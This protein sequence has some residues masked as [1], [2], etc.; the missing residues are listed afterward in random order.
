VKDVLAQ[1]ERLASLI[2][3]SIEPKILPDIEILTHRSA[4]LLVVNIYPSPTRP[5]FLKSRGLDVGTYVRLGSSNRKA[6][7][8]LIEE[9]KRFSRGQAF[10]EIQCHISTLKQ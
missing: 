4:Q 6:D 8:N 2:C 1:E 5:H 9:M 10:D 7:A 3:D